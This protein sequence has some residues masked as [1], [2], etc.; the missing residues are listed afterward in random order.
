MDPLG[1]N[2]SPVSASSRTVFHSSPSA[3]DP[4]RSDAVRNRPGTCAPSRSSRVS[5]KGESVKRLT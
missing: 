3:T 1:T 2:G 5:R 4:D